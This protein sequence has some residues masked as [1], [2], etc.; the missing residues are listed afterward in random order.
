MYRYG[1]L[2]F[3]SARRRPPVGNYLGHDG[4]F[5]QQIVILAFGRSKAKAIASFNDDQIT[6]EVP[7]PL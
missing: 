2:S 5:L 7:S 4:N 1:Q 3:S 6:T